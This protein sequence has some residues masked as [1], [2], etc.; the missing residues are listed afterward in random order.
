[1]ISPLTKWNKLSF[2][3]RNIVPPVLQ[4]Q[5]NTRSLDGLKILCVAGYEMPLQSNGDSR[6][7]AIGQFKNGAVLARGGFDRASHKIVGGGRCDLFVLV[8]PG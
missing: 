4:N 7:Q 3:E 1:M 5:I 2:D 6:D 8:E